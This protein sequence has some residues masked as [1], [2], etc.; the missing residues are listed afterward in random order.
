MK[1]LLLLRVI[2]FLVSSY[3]H[4]KT[5]YVKSMHVKVISF[6]QDLCRFLIKLFFLGFFFMAGPVIDK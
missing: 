6:V 1:V 2:R 4:L 3:G 5:L